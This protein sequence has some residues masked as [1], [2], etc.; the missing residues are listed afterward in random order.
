[1]VKKGEMDR[2]ALCCW[3]DRICW[4]TNGTL[5]KINYIKEIEK[6]NRRTHW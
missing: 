3:D 1:M 6:E 5:Q 2:M 4:K